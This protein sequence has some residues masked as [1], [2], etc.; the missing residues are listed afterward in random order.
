MIHRAEH[1]QV[2]NREYAPGAAAEQEA[3]HAEQPV[4]DAEDDAE[5]ARPRK[6][7]RES[8]VE[9]ESA[10]D[11]VDEIVVERQVRADEV[12]L[13]RIGGLA[14]DE[15]DYPDQDERDAQDCC[16]GFRHD[17]AVPPWEE[18]VD[19]RAGRLTFSIAAL[20]PLSDS[21]RSSEWAHCT[22]ETARRVQGI[23]GAGWGSSEFKLWL[24]LF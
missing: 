3:A 9:G 10:G 14:Y 17:C 23:F 21:E 13:H 1:E 16:D 15:A 6:R 20:P 4:D 11:D 22:T 12:R 8:E 19:E 24:V 7:P 18:K 2:V 5:E